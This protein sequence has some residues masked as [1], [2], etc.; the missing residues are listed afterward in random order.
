MAIAVQANI[1]VAWP[2]AAAVPTGWVHVAELDS[3]YVVGAAAG[4]DT[5]LITAR[6]N[7]THVHTSPAHTPIQ[8]AHTGGGISSSAAYSNIVGGTGTLI[9]GAGHKHTLVLSSVTAVNS[10]STITV[11]L[12]ANDLLHTK[13]VWIKS[14]GTP[15][16][17]P[18]GSI[19]FWGTDALPAGW[20]RTAGDFYLK[21]AASGGTTA[22]ANTHTHTSPAHTHGQNSH[23]HTTPATSSAPDTAISKGAILAT[24]VST[25]THTH[26][27]AITAATAVNQ[28]VTT[29]LGVSN[30]E[31]PF[32]YINAIIS[33]APDYPV[34]A[35]AV[36]LGTNALVPTGW[37]RFTALDTFWPKCTAANGQV[38]TTG[39]TT[40][41][42]HTA[43][44]CQP[45]QNV[46]LHTM[47]NVSI[48]GTRKNTSGATIAPTGTHTHTWSDDGATTATNQAAAVTIDACT[49][50]AAYPLNRTVIFVQLVTPQSGTPSVI[51][52]TPIWRVG[53]R[54]DMHTQ[55]L[56]RATY[57]KR[58]RGEG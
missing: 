57:R 26:D 17:F 16:S 19:A 40:T 43:D 51:G 46:H 27:V 29:A 18:T 31:P 49:V 34:G 10:A 37:T 6:G 52:G 28:A 3:V 2:S 9:A 11:D 53:Y 21:G 35:I 25:D 41:H 20:S 30:H 47:A 48:T 58:R 24:T 54:E 56:T 44:A 13:V 55:D 39:G 5:D 22:G 33:A 4:A 15:A 42:T 23:N 1:A 45:I 32:M 7:A 14:D 8:D 50:G 38:L 12:T 36:W